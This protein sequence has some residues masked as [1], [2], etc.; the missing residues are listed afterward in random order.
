MDHYII[1]KLILI[2]SYKK[3]LILKKR[4][5]TTPDIPY[6][7]TTDEFCEYAFTLL[8]GNIKLVPTIAR[9][10]L[11]GVLLRFISLHTTA[12]L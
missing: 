10:A 12:E 6:R 9:V 2:S 8:E 1:T 5:Y 4:L 7:I 11:Y 3:P